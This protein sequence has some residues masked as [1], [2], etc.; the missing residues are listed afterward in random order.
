LLE[1]EDECAMILRNGCK[2]QSAR[3]LTEEDLKRT[4]QCRVNL[5]LPVHSYMY[6]YVYSQGCNTC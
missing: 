2:Y 1:L 4:H 6:I 3:R 5:D